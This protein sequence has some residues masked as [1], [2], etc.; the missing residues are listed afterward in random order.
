MI[1]IYNGPPMES[2]PRHFLDGPIYATCSYLKPK[3]HI[4]VKL[5]VYILVEI[6]PRTS[7]SLLVC[8]GC[9]VK[10]TPCGSQTNRLGGVKTGI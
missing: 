9:R 5:S 4:K 1:F 6:S 8:T 10:E 7:N 2:D 3:N